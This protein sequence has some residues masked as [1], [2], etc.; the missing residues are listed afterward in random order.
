MKQTVVPVARDINARLVP[1]GEPVAIPRGSFVTLAQTLGRAFTI[2]HQGNMARVE[3]DFADAL[4][5][6]VELPAYTARPDG[7]VDED[8]VWA[9]MRDVYDPEI[10][11]NVV[12]LGLI[13]GLEI[14]SGRVEVTM[15]L[16]SPTC[17]MGPVLVHDIEEGIRA[18][19]HVEDVAVALVFEPPWSREM[20]TEE[21]QL[22][23]GIY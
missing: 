13:Y 1:S 21:A 10:P 20:M 15:T 12:D 22:E 23:L 8:H 2:I 4:G 5:L 6:E 11:V 18:V 9:A 3:A 17:G 14:D 16:T 7:A 19:P